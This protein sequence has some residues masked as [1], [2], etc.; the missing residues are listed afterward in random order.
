MLVLADD[1]G[2]EVDL[3]D[4]A[5]GLHSARYAGHRRAAPVPTRP[6]RVKLVEELIKRDAW[7]AGDE[8]DPKTRVKARFRCVLA[9]IDPLGASEDDGGTVITAEGNL[10]GLHRARGSRT[11]RLR[12]RPRSFVPAAKEATGRTMAEL[13]FEEKL[14][15][16]HRGRA[17]EALVPELGKLL[18][19]RKKAL[20][21]LLAGKRRS[22]LS[23]ARMAPLYKGYESL[24]RYG[25][26]GPR[27]GDQ[28]RARLVG[29]TLARRP[30]RRR[31][32]LADGGPASPSAASPGF[33]QLFIVARKMTREAEGRGGARPQGGRRAAHVPEG[34]RTRTSAT[35][36]T[37]RRSMTDAAEPRELSAGIASVAVAGPSAPSS[38][39]VA[40]FA[41]G[42]H[43]GESVAAGAGADGPRRVSS[44]AG[45][46]ALSSTR[47]TARTRRCGPR[48]ACLKLFA[49]FGGTWWLLSSGLV[50]PLRS[51][52]RNRGPSRRL[53]RRRRIHVG[54]GGESW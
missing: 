17:F 54:Q 21:S 24:G 15:I 40:W 41:A 4:G 49:L 53:G 3:L 44:S 25:T 19:A 23:E 37:T 26:V 18:E 51:R 27:T 20:D 31:T 48:W 36:A 28:H 29:R 8:G 30:L 52:W 13:G 32:R 11:A 46:S 6:N 7:A 43:V 2:L 50:H 42:A 34:A 10:R 12:V 5:P 33:R 35:I 1:S 45:S 39:P 22:R 9:V 16:S 38:R 14:V 47:R